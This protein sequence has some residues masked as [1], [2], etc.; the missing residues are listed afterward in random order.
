MNEQVE[1]IKN[2][3]RKEMASMA[4]EVEPLSYAEAYD[5]MDGEIEMAMQMQTTAKITITW[6]EDDA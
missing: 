3:V 6:D 2:A 5:F 4:I 1:R